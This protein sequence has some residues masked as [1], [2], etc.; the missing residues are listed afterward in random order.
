[1]AQPPNKYLQTN[2]AFDED[3][4]VFR[5]KLAQ[6]HGFTEEDLL[7]NRGGAITGKQRF[8]LLVEAF[9]PAVSSGVVLL[10]WLCLLYFRDLML[11]AVVRDFMSRAWSFFLVISIATG[12]AFVLGVFKSARLGWLVLLDIKHG[13]VDSMKG[14]VSTY[15]DKSTEYGVSS[16]FSIRREHYYYWIGDDKFEVTPSGY[17]LLVKQFDIQAAPPIKIY[18]APHS[19]ILLSA[20]PLLPIKQQPSIWLRP[21][22]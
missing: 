8:R 10:G 12:A 21:A 15:S 11:P 20:E 9:R 19:R 16:L 22:G 18:F 6:A 14:R 13:E 4:H 3:P 17:E 7:V 2:Q 1:M 5:A